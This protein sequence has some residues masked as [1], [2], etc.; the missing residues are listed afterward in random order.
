M[1]R[2][3]VGLFCYL[4]VFL[5]LSVIYLSIHLSLPLSVL[6]SICLSVYLSFCLSIYLSICLFTVSVYLSV[7]LSIYLSIYLYIYLSV[8]LFVYRSICVSNEATQR[9]FLNFLS[10]QHQ[11]W[12]NS[13]RLPSETENW[14]QSW[15]PHTNAFCVFST[16]SVQS[17]APAT[18][19]SRV[20][21]S[22]ARVTQNHLSNLEDLMLQNATLSGNQISAL[23]S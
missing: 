7:F 21:R 11:K 6:L 12:V 18:K 2:K 8:C 10:W 17:I 16:P 19:W 23:T 3:V 14:V 22:A 9:D 1:D 15:R 20:M 5:C 13:A 4:S